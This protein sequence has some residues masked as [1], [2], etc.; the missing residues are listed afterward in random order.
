MLPRAI[1]GA[2]S[3]SAAFTIWGDTEGYINLLSYAEVNL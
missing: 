2:V 3:N 1:G